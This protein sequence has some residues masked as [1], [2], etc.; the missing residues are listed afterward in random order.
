MDQRAHKKYH[1]NPQVINTTPVMSCDVKSYMY[2]TSI[3]KA[4]YRETISSG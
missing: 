1:N 4:F 2:E 3:I